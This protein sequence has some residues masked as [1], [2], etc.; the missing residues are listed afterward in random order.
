MFGNDAHAIR[1][2]NVC[3]LASLDMCLCVTFT[4]VVSYGFVYFPTRKG[5]KVLIPKSAL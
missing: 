2:W 5:R 1:V 3:L 4:F